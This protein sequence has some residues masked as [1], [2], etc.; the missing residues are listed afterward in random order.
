MKAK[1]IGGVFLFPR[2]GL[3]IPYLS[4]KW[5][6]K[7]KMICKYAD[8]IG[9]EAW[10]FD[11]YPYPSG[12]S[13]GEVLLRHPEAKQKI[14]EDIIHTVSGSEELLIEIP[15]ADVIYARAVRIRDDNTPDFAET[16]DLLENIGNL[17][18]QDIYQRTGL[19]EYNNKRY[20]TY[21]PRKY[22]ASC[23]PSGTWRLLIVVQKTIGDF[24]Y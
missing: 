22:L 24:K 7:I 4:V 14:L 13:G 18:Y 12:M 2:Q 19:T 5:F 17:Q 16:I 21:E 9:L 11:E 10:L 20:L 23:L 3:E 8:T 6:E 1:G 15:F